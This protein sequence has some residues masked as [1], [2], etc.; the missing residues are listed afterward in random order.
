MQDED[1][2][3]SGLG[4]RL[5]YYGGSVAA[6]VLLVLLAIW[7]RNPAGSKPLTG[8]ETPSDPPAIVLDPDNP[9]GDPAAPPERVAVLGGLKIGSFVAGWR[10]ASMTITSKPEVKGSLAVL[11]RKGPKAFAMWIAPKGQV[12][13]PAPFET[14]RQ[15]I[16]NG[17]FVETD[18]LE[19]G[20]PTEEVLAHIRYAEA[21]PT[22]AP[23]A[24]PQ[25]P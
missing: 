4:R 15:S 10:I 2:S 9:G 23:S 25:G 19:A 22:I 13:T 7:N 8:P 3:K 17:H 21:E 16:Y 20:T 12:N 5:L 18:W 14:E 1:T 6:V 11:F 24:S